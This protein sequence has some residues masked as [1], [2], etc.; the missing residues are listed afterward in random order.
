MTAHHAFRCPACGEETRWRILFNALRAVAEQ[1]VPACRCGASTALHLPFEFALD[2]PDKNA[3]VL[4][5]FLPH[6]LEYWQDSRGR[7]VTFDP[8]L[9]IT[10]REGHDQAV[11]LPNWHVI[12]DGEK[13]RRKYGQWAPFMDMKLFED[14][15]TQARSTGFLNHEA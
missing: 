5:S 10:K 15:L 4:A 9:V 3:E 6:Q 12:R 11:W 8:F 14:L 1:N 13:E 2:V 7:T